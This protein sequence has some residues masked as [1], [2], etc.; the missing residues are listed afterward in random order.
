MQSSGLEDEF[1]YSEEIVDDP[2]EPYNRVITSF[3]DSLYFIVLNPTATGYSAV[4]PEGSRIG[5]RNFFHNILFPIRFV[6][7]ILQL[8]FA[9]AGIETARFLIN[10]TMGFVGFLD[11]A[12]SCF[13]LETPDE[14]FGQTLGFYKIGSLFHIDWPFIGPSNFRDSVGYVGD[15][16][17]NPINYIPNMWIVMGIHIF[18]KINQ[19]S[20]HLGEYEKLKK[21]SVDYY[22]QIRDSYE[23]FRKK[24]IKE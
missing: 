8:K 13:C 3:N 24:E 15:L 20:L 5:I 7:N 12:K 16:F 2:L 9:K 18:E 21:E 19:T 14:D 11:P 4:V 6:N 23:Q 10:S 22:L 17:L 1:S